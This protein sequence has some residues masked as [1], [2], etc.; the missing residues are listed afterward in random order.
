[1]KCFAQRGHQ[2]RAPGP[3][4][5]HPWEIDPGQPRRW[6]GSPLPF[7]RHYGRLATTERRLRALLAGRRFGSRAEVAP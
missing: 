7:I 6:V 5:L 3:L 1:V 4:Y 2:Y